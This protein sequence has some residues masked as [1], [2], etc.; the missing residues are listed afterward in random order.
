MVNTRRDVF[1][2]ATIANVST[3]VP[4]ELRKI[5][6]RLP[7]NYEVNG[8]VYPIHDRMRPGTAF[9]VRPFGLR[10]G[11]VR[12]RMYTRSNESGS[13]SG[14]LETII[15]RSENEKAD[16][17]TWWQSEEI[18]RIYNKRGTVDIRLDLME[19]TFELVVYENSQKFER[20]NLRLESDKDWPSMRILALAFSTGIT[21]FLAYVRYM[22]RLHFGKTPTSQG[23]QLRLIVSVRSPGFLMEHQ[24]LEELAQAFPEHFQYI[25]VFTRNWPE[26]WTGPQGRI[27]RG[28]QPN[29]LASR[30][31]LSPLQAIVPDLSEWHI[32]VC[33]SAAVRNQLVQG[34]EE[35]NI[36]PQSFRAEVW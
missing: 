18:D 25:P 33:G 6:L 12:R 22:H 20:N 9:L 14:V 36:H 1:V 30:V 15:N 35:S 26:G 2:P 16:T 13:A 24:E 23:V 28:A 10:T 19:E 7:T 21:P 32:R 3:Y 5:A 34:F 8:T 31:D 27:I 4:G 17:S 29:G 11:K